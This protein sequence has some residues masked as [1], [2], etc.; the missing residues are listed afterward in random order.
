[1]PRTVRDIRIF[2]SFMNYYRRFIKGFSQI[3]LPL[4]TLSKKE[5]GQARGRPAMRRE[6]GKALQL[7]KKAVQAFT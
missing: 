2:I 5:P 4:T 3:V 6:E 7:L 1:M